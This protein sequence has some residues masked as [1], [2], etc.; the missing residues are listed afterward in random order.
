MYIEIPKALDILFTLR[1]LY[2]HKHIKSNL[3]QDKL[4]YL[5]ID[6]EILKQ[7]KGLSC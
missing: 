4:K 2:L 5:E 3:E 1:R 7:I 6:E